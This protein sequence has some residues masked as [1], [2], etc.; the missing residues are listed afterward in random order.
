M[1]QKLISLLLA[2]SMMTSMVVTAKAA[3]PSDFS[4]MP[5]NFATQSLLAAVDNGLLSGNNGK[6][7]P[8]DQLTRAQMAAILVRA[9]GAENTTDLSQFTDVSSSAW[10]YDELSAAV[11]MGIFQGNGSTMNPTAAI[12]RQEAF[13]VLARAFSLE[14]DDTSALVSFVDGDAVGAWA[15]EE[16][17][18]MVATGYVQGNGTNLYPTN[19]ITRQEFAVVMDRMVKTYI[20]EAGTYSDLADGSVMINQPDVTLE[21][22]T[23]TGDLIIGDGVGEG[24]VTLDNVTVDGALL[25]RGGGVNSIVITGNSQ[26]GKVIVSKMEGDVRVSVEGNAQ[27]DVVSIEDGKDDVIVQ[28]AIGSLELVATAITVYAADATIAD[29]SVSGDASKVVLADDTTVSTGESVS[30]DTTTDTTTTT[31]TTTTTVTKPGFSSSSSPT[32]YTVTF[33]ADG[34]SDVDSQSI[35]KGYT[36]ETAPETTREGY[37]LLG[38]FTEDGAEFAFDTDT[39]TEAMTLTAQW[40]AGVSNEAELSAALDLGGIIVLQGDITITSAKTI[41][42]DVTLIGAGYEIDGDPLLRHAVA[43]TLA[44]GVDVHVS[45][46]T[47]TTF[48]R[49]NSIRIFYVPAGNDAALTLDGVTITDS[50]DEPIYMEDGTLTVTN[51]TF[52]DLEAD[53][54]NYVAV[55]ISV[56]GDAT[57]TITGNT[58]ENIAK[59]WN[60]DNNQSA[61]YIATGV[62]VK[63]ATAI[64]KDNT[65]TNVQVAV[66]NDCGTVDTDEDAIYGSYVSIAGE[67]LTAFQGHRDIVLAANVSL[68]TDV[69]LTE[70]TSISPGDVEDDFNRGL[71][72]QVTINSAVTIE[73]GATLTINE[74]V[75]LVI[76]ATGSL[77]IEGTLVNNG[78]IVNTGTLNITADAYL[79]GEGEINMGGTFNCEGTI[80]VKTQDALEQAIGFGATKIDMGK[81][82]GNLSIS[83][84]DDITIPDG[85]TVTILENTTV[86]VED[87]ATLTVE[88]GATLTVNGKI[89]GNVDNQSGSLVIYTPS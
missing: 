21:D 24:D 10:Y 48:N 74:G 2:F 68:G 81:T 87:G 77:V 80:R 79:A 4:D 31:T 49:Y 29:V 57:A 17:A 76:G 38:W 33:D 46:V 54:A 69:I 88:D 12:T 23:I 35:R 39:V 15:A 27:V 59:T 16:V 50:A 36:I 6:I 5:D 13:V 11:Q 52:S 9:F 60:S 78:T 28:G 1:K 8:T 26:I 34:G 86:T 63:D 58:F 25:V 66:H 73:E 47:F 67:F 18:A 14:A 64:V 19:T 30:A 83:L 55:A 40:G 85:V 32:Y 70:D 51:S 84:T 37:V 72:T 3:S 89:T 82:S 41:F 22:T 7:M 43:F 44:D 65:F 62:Y 61:R 71:G 56:T 20:S 75:T 45:D 53:I 42:K